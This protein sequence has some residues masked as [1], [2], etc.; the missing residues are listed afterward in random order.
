MAELAGINKDSVVLD[1]CTG[2][3]GLL[4]AAMRKM[5]EDANGDEDKI[6]EIKH[7][8]LIGI[9]QQP[10]MYSLACSNMILRGDGKANM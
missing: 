6:S 10:N 7:N 2:T 5:I 8:Q 4:I 3:G 1:T 9:E